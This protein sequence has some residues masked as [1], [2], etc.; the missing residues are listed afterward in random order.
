M[1]NF[2]KQPG[3]KAFE[4]LAL[5]YL[6][7]AVERFFGGKVRYE[8]CSIESIKVKYG[9]DIT[10]NKKRGVYIVDA[11]TAI[12]LGRVLEKNEVKAALGLYVTESSFTGIEKF[13]NNFEAAL[14]LTLS[15]SS[16][17][18]FEERP[19]QFGDELIGRP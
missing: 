3:A 6:C 9:I 1:I 15:S 13:L 11:K 18:K 10:E 8:A 7:G 19:H 14:A 4:Y 2:I 5:P 12:I 16:Q 17:S